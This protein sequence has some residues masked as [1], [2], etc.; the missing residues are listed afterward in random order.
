MEIKMIILMQIIMIAT[1]LMVLFSFIAAAQLFIAPFRMVRVDEQH[2][3]KD[4]GTGEM[5][6]RETPGS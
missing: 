2:A 6:D 5:F 1:A 3:P 4:R